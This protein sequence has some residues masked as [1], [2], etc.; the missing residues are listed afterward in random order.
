[1]PAQPT[2]EVNITTGIHLTR[3]EVYRARVRALRRV[4]SLHPYGS[5]ILTPL[6]H[7]A[8]HMLWTAPPAVPSAELNHCRAGALPF[9]C[10]VTVARATAPLAK[11]ANGPLSR[12]TMTESSPVFV[13]GAVRTGS[14]MLR[15]MLDSHPQIR[16]PGEFDFLIDKV[17]SDG[18]TPNVK[19]YRRWLS[20]HR[21]FEET[22][23]AVDPRLDYRQLM[24][25]FLEQLQ[26]GGRVVTMNVHRHFER[27][28]PLFPNAR[29]IHLIRDPRDV[30]RSSF[31]LG[32]A[33]N[34]YRGV[35][36]WATAERSWDRLV[37]TLKPDRY[38]EVRYEM[39]LENVVEELTRICRF[40]GLEY[41]PSM[42]NYP[43]RSTYAAPDPRLR[44]QWK[45]QCGAQELQ[46]VDW[47]LG[48]MLLQR[49]YELSGFGPKKPT[50]LERVKIRLQDK[51][52]RVR[53]EVKLYGLG[54]YLE[55][56]LAARLPI[57]WWNDSC[58][59]RIN[60]IDLK[61]LK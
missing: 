19:K 58:Q 51:Y 34:L 48:S 43:S 9:G 16:N 4:K 21:G 20:T 54:L 27:L 5:A 45:R 41:S 23:L 46:W 6:L 44:Y 49:N 29:Y 50:L 61:L 30:A 47:K 57:P 39:L 26:R 14:T 32:M 59:R 33:G 31:G 53:F 10:N 22:G 1:M 2:S 12:S 3:R 40:L 37:A 28:P 15:L 25:S 38:L 17:G 52:Y 56:L 24:C 13:V 18:S 7:I 8:G 36:I 11:E 42:L 60:Q 55:S 35:E